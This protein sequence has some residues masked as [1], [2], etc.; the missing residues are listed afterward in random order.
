MGLFLLATRQQWQKF[1]KTLLFLKK[2]INS[3][4][5]ETLR[6]KWNLWESLL[7][8]NGEL[9]RTFIIQEMS[10][11]HKRTTNTGKNEKFARKIM[12]END[13]HTIN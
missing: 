5:L 4:W 1:V 3:N 13:V 9:L 8:L 12:H 10:Y 7:Y 2:E 6:I 11:D